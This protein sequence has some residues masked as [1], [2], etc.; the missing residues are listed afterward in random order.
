MI[1]WTVRKLYYVII[2]IL[3]AITVSPAYA[4]PNKAGAIFETGISSVTDT[5]EDRD[6][7]GNFDYYRYR[8]KFAREASNTTSCWAAY[9]RRVRDYETSDNLD[10]EYSAAQA[11]LTH[12]F[13]NFSINPLT[14]DLDIG[15]KVKDYDNSPSSTYNRSDAAVNLSHKH[16]DLWA[17]SWKNGFVNYNYTKSD[18][19]QLKLFTKLSGWA[20][21]LDEKLK[22]SPS[23]K[24]QEI[25]AERNE[26]D[27][28]EQTV[29][30]RAA[31]KTNLPYLSEAAGFFEHGRNDTKDSDDEERDDDLR[32]RYQK[33][34]V[35]TEHPLV[36]KLKTG[37][38]Y[39]HLRRH[40]TDNANSYRHWLI[41]NKTKL[42]AFEDKISKTSF[43]FEYQHREANF[44]TVSTLNYIRNSAVVKLSYEIKDSWELAP[45][46]VFKSFDYP[47][48]PTSTLKQ[49]EAKVEFL[50]ELPTNNLELVLNYRYIWKDYKFKTDI[51]QWAAKAGIEY[52]F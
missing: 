32:F 3:S 16:E 43:W 51:R 1:K 37:F 48:N 34:D 45:A 8:L 41:E 15:Y 26:K 23:Y 25:D 10:S 12:T 5:T 35:T 36:E 27:R 4:L 40:Y 50:K 44:T 49:Y 31:Y 2:L 30:C 19:D 13:T 9:E 7:S 14:A 17:I 46:F 33:W 52:K 28:N 6:V 22:I 20:K 18:N 39:G 42:G 11:S 24:Y 38:K 21:F 29:N 47:N